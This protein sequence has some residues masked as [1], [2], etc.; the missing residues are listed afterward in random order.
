MY[1]TSVYDFTKKFACLH[2]NVILQRRSGCTSYF[3]CEQFFCAVKG[4]GLS[5]SE[6]R[7]MMTDN[8]TLCE[9]C[10]FCNSPPPPLLSGIQQLKITH[11]LMHVQCMNF[12]RGPC[13]EMQNFNNVICDLGKLPFC[14]KINL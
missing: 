4:A 11:C 10:R 2:S 13:L 12:W 8:K 5:L 6:H 7:F 9:Q 1:F 14:Q 3:L